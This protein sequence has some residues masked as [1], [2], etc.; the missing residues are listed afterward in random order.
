MFSALHFGTDQQSPS[1]VYILCPLYVRGEDPKLMKVSP[2]S[3]ATRVYRRDVHIYVRSYTRDVMCAHSIDWSFI[4]S[5]I[6]RRKLILPPICINVHTS[7][8][9]LKLFYQSEY[10]SANS[11]EF[12]SI[13]HNCSLPIWLS[14]QLD[15]SPTLGI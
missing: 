13:T 15:C 8:A 7:I 9:T 12:V 11:L 1:R 10:N 6:S 3:R 5:K 14:N 2:F 4:D